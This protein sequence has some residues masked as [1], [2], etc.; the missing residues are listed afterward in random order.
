MDADLR[1]LVS[2]ASWTGLAR[3]QG[4]LLRLL[5]HEQIIPCSFAELPDE[6]MVMIYEA[7]VFFQDDQ[8]SL[9]ADDSTI[10]VALPLTT[11]VTTY[12]EVCSGL[13]CMGMA[14]SFLGLRCLASMDI[15]QLA[16]DSQRLRGPTP[17]LQGDV[18]CSRH[19]A[20]LHQTPRPARGL[21]LSGFPCQPLSTQGDARGCQTPGHLSFM[22]YV[23]FCGSKGIGGQS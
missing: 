7:K 4:N 22:G 21:L 14:A 11:E 1:A 20:L 17:V 5:A 19:R 18:Q 2:D 10:L 15:N 6:Q 8:V 12:K 13:G 16:C 9:R 23:V 3:R